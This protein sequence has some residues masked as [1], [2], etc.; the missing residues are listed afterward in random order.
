MQKE[1][2]RDIESCQRSECG[3]APR[4]EQDTEMKNVKKELRKEV[5]ACRA[6]MPEHEWQEK[7]AQI[8]SRILSLPAFLAAEHVLCYVNY[9]KEAETLTLL[10]ECLRLKKHVYCPHVTGTEMDFYEISDISELHKGF[11]GIPEPE[12]RAERLFRMT[13]QEQE[14]ILMLM[15]GAVFDRAHHRIGY[16]G[17]Y[18]DRYLK[19]YLSES[20]CTAALAFTFQVREQIPYEEHDICPDMIITETGCI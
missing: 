2:K 14:L 5:L 4:T 3:T 18:Y 9:K 17:G 6:A 19:Q 13:G 15:P 8:R 16:G 1:L 10:K 11:H 12:Q 20:L 7:S